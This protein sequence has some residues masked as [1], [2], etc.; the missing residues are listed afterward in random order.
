MEILGTLASIIILISFIPKNIT[1]IRFINLIGSILFVIYGM[2]INSFSVIL[3]N[4]MLITVHT[5]YL[6]REV[7]K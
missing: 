6:V 5:Y 7:I 4:V 2:T 1:K 3:L